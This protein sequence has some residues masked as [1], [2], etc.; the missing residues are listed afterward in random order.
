MSSSA[1]VTDTRS[2]DGTFN[3]IIEDANN[4][5]GKSNKVVFFENEGEMRTRKRQSQHVW[6]SFREEQREDMMHLK[7]YNRAKM[8]NRVIKYLENNTVQCPTE[9]NV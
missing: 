2:G 4:R 8:Y 5:N 6:K 7:D 9:Y 3:K 1:K